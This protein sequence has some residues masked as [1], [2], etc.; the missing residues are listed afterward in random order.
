M[1]VVQHEARPERDDTWAAGPRGYIKKSL[2]IAQ[3][4]AAGFEYVGESDVNQNDK[5][6]PGAEDIVWRLPPSLSGS[7]DNPKLRIQL[8]TV[9]ESNR[10]TLKFRKPK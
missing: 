9:G 10:M 2:V 6:I 7:K 4:E 5:D 1:G 8:M 3:A